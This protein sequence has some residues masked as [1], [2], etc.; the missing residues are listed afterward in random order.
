MRSFL[1]I[2]LLLIYSLNAH[3]QRSLVI[4][5][6][7]SPAA[8]AIQAYKQ[9]Q[10]NLSCL[11]LTSARGQSTTNENSAVSSVALDYYSI[12]CR[13]SQK[14]SAAV[15]EAIRFLLT[16]GVPAWR[17]RMHLD[18]AH[19]FF[20]EKRWQDALEHFRAGSINHLTNEEIAASQFGQA[21]ALFSLKRYH[22]ALPLF[23]SIRQLN[24]SPFQHAALYYTGLLYLS[25]AKWEQAEKCF[26]PL[27]SHSLYG[28]LAIFHLGQLLVKKGDLL[29]AVSYLE[30]HRSLYVDTLYPSIPFKQLLGHAYYAQEDFQKALPLLTSYATLSKVLDREEQ[31]ELSVTQLRVGQLDEAINGFTTLLGVKDSLANYAMFQLA[32]SRLRQGDRVGA[33][34]AFFYSSLNNQHQLLKSLSHFLYGKLSYELGN[35][36]EAS[37]VFELYNKE[38]ISSPYLE[39]SRELLFSSLAASA[40]FKRAMEVLEQVK[41]PSALVARSL[42]LV[43]Y[44]RA[45]ELIY[46]GELSLARQLLLQALKDKPDKALQPLLYFWL[47]EICYRQK[48]FDDAVLQFSKYLSLGGPTVGEA[49]RIHAF[50]NIGYAYY[51]LNQF[52]LALP[53][54]EKVSYGAVAGNTSIEQDAQ[55]RIADCQYMLRQYKL[56]KTGYQ[57]I[58]DLDVAASP[59]A[60]FQLAAVAGVTNGIEKINLLRQLLE[61]YPTGEFV[62]EANM[63]LADTYMAEERFKDAIPVLERILSDATSE[64]QPTV[65][66]KLG[67]IYYNINENEKALHQFQQLIEKYPS[68]PEASDALEELKAVYVELGLTTE[69]TAYL[70][71]Q[72]FAV[73]VQLEDSLQYIAAAQLF[74]EQDFDKA[75]PAFVKYLEQFPKG[76]YWVDA[77]FLL[78]TCYQQK[79]LWTEA[80]S[81][82]VQIIQNAQGRYF[83]EAILAAA[84]INFF[85]QK[86]YSAAANYYFQFLSTR[87]TEADR[88][89]AYRGLLRSYYHQKNWSEASRYGDSLILLKERTTEDQALHA[90]VAAK[91]QI[92]V[93][94]EAVALQHLQRVLQFNKAGLAAEARY[95]MA[96]SYYR[97]QQFKLAEQHAFE[98]INRSGSYA[99]WVTKSYLLLGDIYTAQK[100]LF[101]AKATYQSVLE[102]A[103]DPQLQKEAEEKLAQI[104]NNKLGN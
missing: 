26:Q 19:Y 97:Q 94:K 68:S 47:G 59:Y 6:Q 8:W 23:N 43:R 45:V 10:Q 33:K 96:A 65:L 86:N 15:P 75:I 64:W 34:N 91:F 39:E 61:K 99:F 12:S 67:V 50:Y 70:K 77:S 56:A 104:E 90:L 42:P 80:L 35:F 69:Y 7:D 49:S 14:E 24:N 103:V 13:L 78:G 89:E 60:L 72:G 2:G 52:K 48:D 58:V 1:L 4:L 102:N 21:Y 100:D 3:A 81:Q 20:E 83:K 28:R 5:E 18:L 40:N 32:E 55:L 53:Y 92:E 27:T 54:F 71:K 30:E 38:N 76:G 88:L 11:L 101:N 46:D 31:Y 51:E 37:R 95:E 9:G 63:A 29:A 79:Q 66:L 84:R 57:R 41:Q 25:E 62:A 74:D 16:N 17:D 22:E 44:G 98:T 36:D 87:V 93:G 73:S 85:E 82:F